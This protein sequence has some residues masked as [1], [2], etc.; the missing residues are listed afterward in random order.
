[1]VANTQIY[2][3]ATIEVNLKKKN[4]AEI[5]VNMWKNIWASSCDWW[6]HPLPSMGPYCDNLCATSFCLKLQNVFD[7]I[8]EFIYLRQI[9]FAY[10]SEQ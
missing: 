10:Q 5:E 4:W 3:W 2:I 7:Q 9:V 1:M 6:W 8:V